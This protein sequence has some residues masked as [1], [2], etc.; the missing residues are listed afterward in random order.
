MLDSYERRAKEQGASEVLNVINKFKGAVKATKAIVNTSKYLLDKVDKS[1]SM[2]NVV[3]TDYEKDKNSLVGKANNLIAKMDKLINGGK[4][5]GNF[6]HSGRP[7]KVGG[8]GNGGVPQPK[9]LIG[10]P[11][12]SLGVLPEDFKKA[13]TVAKRRGGNIE[14]KETDHKT[15]TASN[16]FYEREFDS[17]REAKAF[18]DGYDYAKDERRFQRVDYV[19]TTDDRGATRWDVM[20]K[21]TDYGVGEKAGFKNPIEAQRWAEGYNA[22]MIA[23]E[24]EVPSDKWI[25]M[26]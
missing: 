19:R 6:G 22:F 8:S 18:K 1:K 23:A 24:S 21:G 5:S 15:Y 10:S 26:R 3:I 4:G 20:Y 12:T 11:D 2:H 9:E 17:K 25:R 13:K 14:V 16:K 7:G